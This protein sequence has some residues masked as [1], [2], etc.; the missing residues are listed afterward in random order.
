MECEIPISEP[1]RYLA[2]AVITVHWLT[3]KP[4]PDDWRRLLETTLGY[5][6]TP[7][8]LHSSQ[9]A[10][11]SSHQHLMLAHFPSL[12]TGDKNDSERIAQAR[13]NLWQRLTRLEPSLSPDVGKLTVVTTIV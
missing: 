8:G 12:S 9:E 5:G 11:C 7:Y 1:G 10:E 3:D 2:V 13:K 6:W 4:N